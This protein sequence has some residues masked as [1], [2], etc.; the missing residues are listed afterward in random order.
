MV[1][2]DFQSVSESLQA[3]KTTN[4]REKGKK[5]RGKRE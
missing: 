1:R 4:L 5:E 2:S 3:G